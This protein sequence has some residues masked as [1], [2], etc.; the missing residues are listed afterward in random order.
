MSDPFKG[1]TEKVQMHVRIPR[2]LKEFVH[3]FADVRG[4]TVSDIVRQNIYSIWLDEEVKSVVQTVEDK[5]SEDVR[6]A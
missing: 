5:G 2:Y 3:K 4:T 1:Q 6:D